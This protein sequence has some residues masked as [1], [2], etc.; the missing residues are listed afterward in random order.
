MG[1]G[2][3]TSL[4]GIHPQNRPVMMLHNSTVIGYKEKDGFEDDSDK[5][6]VLPTFTK[7]YALQQV[8]DE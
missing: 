8:Q 5:L 7:D 6:I 3:G 2:R 1:S 4:W